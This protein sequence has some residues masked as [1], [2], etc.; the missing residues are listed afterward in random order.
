MVTQ[1]YRVEGPV[2][3]FLTTTA[4]DI[5]EELLNRCLV[6][7]VD[8]GREQ[9]AAI[10][11]L[12]RERETLAGLL[13]GEARAQVLATHRAAQRLLR[14]LAVV[15]PFAEQL[16][17]LD[18]RTRAR[19]DHMKY[20]ALIRTITLLHQYQRPVKTV[21][22][23]G[24]SLAYVEATLDDIAAANRLAHDV[25]GRCLDEMPPQTRRLLALLEKMVGERCVAAKMERGDILFSRRQVRDFTGWGDTQ[26]KIHLGRLA[27]LEYV[28]TH[29]ADHGQGFV[30]ELVYDGLGK[31]GGR[32]LSGLLDVEK[33]RA[34]HDY[35]AQRSGQNG[36][37]SGVGRPLVGGWSGGSRASK[38][39]ASPSENPSPASEAGENAHLDGAALA[40]AS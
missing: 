12:Q 20:L 24:K 31:D 28:L 3:I 32:F 29:R 36:E 10:H 23:G 16:T 5:D 17:F 15:N 21:Q 13:R 27:E 6:L 22:H 33:L 2:M 19:R 7:T 26:L 11:R 4:V 39:V 30:Y 25:L 14:P 18:D 37:R 34:A 40:V 35:D 8:E 38:N 1:E 9:T